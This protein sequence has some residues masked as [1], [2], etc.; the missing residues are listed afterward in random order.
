MAI[1][2][3]TLAQIGVVKC[4]NCSPESSKQHI[5]RSGHVPNFCQRCQRMTDHSAFDPEHVDRADFFVY[6]R[7]GLKVECVNGEVFITNEFRRW[8]ALL[9]AVP[10][11]IMFQIE[12][13]EKIPYGSQ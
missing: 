9:K 11:D 8:K 2:I 6:D 13:V 5:L 7:G 1:S 12:M 3:E 4:T 10:D